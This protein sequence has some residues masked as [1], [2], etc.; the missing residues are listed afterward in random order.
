MAPGSRTHAPHREQFDH[1]YGPDLVDRWKNGPHYYA[2]ILADSGAD[3]ERSVVVEDSEKMR[4]AAGSV[5][6][7]SFASL[8]ALH[9]ALD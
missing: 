3:P 1:L 9:K 4:V 2:A 6:L 7:Q 8:D 5:G